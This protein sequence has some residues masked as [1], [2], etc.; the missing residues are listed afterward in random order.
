[1]TSDLSEDEQRDHAPGETH[2]PLSA[3]PHGPCADGAGQTAATRVEA[4]NRVP[5]QE[6]IPAQHNPNALAKTLLRQSQAH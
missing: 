5:D 3:G 4:R 1:M 2:D 6:E